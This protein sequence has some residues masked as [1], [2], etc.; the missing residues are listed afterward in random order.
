M[1]EAT[2]K[3]DSNGQVVAEEREVDKTNPKK[4]NQKLAQQNTEQDTLDEEDTH[5]SRQKQD[6]VYDRTHHHTHEAIQPVIEK[7]VY[8]TEV[9]HNK[10]LVH[11][12]VQEEDVVEA[13]EVLPTEREQAATLPK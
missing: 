2:D 11:E 7:D 4:L 10:K 8:D 1:A 3:V 6:E 12:H 9:R 13:T 5:E